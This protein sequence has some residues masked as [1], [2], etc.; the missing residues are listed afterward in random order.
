M[1]THLLSTGARSARSS[2]IRDLLEHAKRPDVI[3]L[4]G[5]IPAPELFPLEELARAAVAAIEELGSSAVQYGLTQGEYYFREWAA[6]WTGGDAEPDTIVVTTG[7]QQGLDLVGR[8]LIDPG[9][10]VREGGASF[11]ASRT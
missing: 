8:V 4:A 9:D 1:A 5:G 7:S 11:T 3:S 10:K 6:A 2:V